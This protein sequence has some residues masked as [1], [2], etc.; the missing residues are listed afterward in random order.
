MMTG[1]RTC[2]AVDPL[3]DVPTELTLANWL[4][5]IQRKLATQQSLNLQLQRLA[6]RSLLAL[7]SFTFQL[8]N[9]AIHRR[10]LRILLRQLNLQAIFGFQPGFGLNLA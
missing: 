6:L 8:F 10:H 1:R 3:N 4:N 9:G 2:R 7:F 5:Q